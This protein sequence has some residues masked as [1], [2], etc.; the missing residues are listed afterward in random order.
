VRQ[1]LPPSDPALNNSDPD[2]SLTINSNI[3]WRFSNEVGMSGTSEFGP[4]SMNS[5]VKSYD[6]EQVAIHEIIHGL[7]FV[8]GWSK[9]LSDGGFYPSFEEYDSLGQFAGLAPSW[10]FDKYTSDAINGAWMRDYDTAI[11][12]DILESVDSY[13]SNWRRGFSNT[14]GYKIAQALGQKVGV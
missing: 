10:I 9:W 14:T 4:A 12:R 6:F 13:A 3:N 2:L 8:S 5:S 7:G 11:R 1:I